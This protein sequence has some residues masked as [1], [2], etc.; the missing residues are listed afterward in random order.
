M[1]NNPQQS[2]Q[3]LLV[4]EVGLSQAKRMVQEYREL[5]IDMSNGSVIHVLAERNDLLLSMISLSNF[6]I[7][8]KVLYLKKEIHGE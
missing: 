6:G 7:I 4:D 2:I 5:G 3:K 8:A 1:A